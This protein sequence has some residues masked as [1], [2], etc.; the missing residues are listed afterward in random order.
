MKKSFFA[1]ALFVVFAG[2]LNAEPVIT[3]FEIQ[4][5]KR[6]K[7]FAAQRDLKKFIGKEASAETLHNIE[8]SLQADNLFTNISIE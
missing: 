5:L 3:K 1:V 7:E 4:G 2:F 8:N 6:T